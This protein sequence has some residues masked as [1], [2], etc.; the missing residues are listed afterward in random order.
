MIECI[1]FP[2][3]GTEVLPGSGLLGSFQYGLL[4]S[5]NSQNLSKTLS[6]SKQ[7]GDLFSFDFGIS[8]EKPVSVIEQLPHPGFCYIWGRSHYKTFDGQV[9]R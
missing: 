8:G 9:F 4:N 6:L 3:A 2:E 5:V 1:V 7:I